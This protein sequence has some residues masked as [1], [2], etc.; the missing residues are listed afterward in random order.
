MNV[1]VPRPPNM[2][3][4]KRESADV[5][6]GN[7]QENNDEVD[8]KGTWLLI[9]NTVGHTLGYVRLDDHDHD[10]TLHEIRQMI[11]D[12]LASQNDYRHGWNF[13]SGWP[14]KLI[15]KSE[16]QSMFAKSVLPAITVFSA[17]SARTLNQKADPISAAAMTQYIDSAFSSNVNI[18]MNM[19]FPQSGQTAAIQPLPISAMF[20]PAAAIPPNTVPLVTPLTQ[21]AGAQ[22]PHGSS[23][24]TLLPPLS[25][26]SDH[27]R[28]SGSSQAPPMPTFSPPVLSQQQIAEKAQVQRKKL[29]ALLPGNNRWTPDSATAALQRV[30]HRTSPKMASNA[31]RTPKAKKPM[32]PPL[33]QM[34]AAGNVIETV[35]AQRNGPMRTP[36]RETQRDLYCPECQ[37]TFD[38]ERGYRVHMKRDH[39]VTMARG[40]NKER[41][42]ECGHP[43]CDRAFYQRSDL[44][45]HQR[46]HLGVKP[47]K[48]SVC[49]KEFTQRGSLYRHIKSSHKGVKDHRSLV[50]LQTEETM[51]TQAKQRRS[52]SQSVSPTSNAASQPP[53]DV[54]SDLPPPL[55]GAN[56]GNYSSPVID[57]S[58]PPMIE[59]A[60]SKEEGKAVEEAVGDG[61]PPPL[62]RMNAVGNEHL[63]ASDNRPPVVASVD[64]EDVEMKEEKS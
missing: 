18:N 15:T 35:N 55:V 39:D 4:L 50:L 45:R 28:K 2:E 8:E 9:T 3:P 48:C 38:T 21:I 7:Q 49:L 20:T 10:L 17:H 59:Q 12:K 62:I 29:Q 44:R 16:E 41:R 51:P 27:S 19:G 22:P 5:A 42:F 34:D 56:D 54:S 40:R 36:N 52:E 13:G 64:T 24:N 63:D 6:A 1:A 30:K 14:P 23:N 61:V 33:K 60:A 46:V 58:V 32:L 47:F 37:K 57:D 25:G 53:A 11:D 26:E 31:K 43:G